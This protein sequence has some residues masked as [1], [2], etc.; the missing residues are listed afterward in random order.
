MGRGP[1][2]EYWG[3]VLAECFLLFTGAV[4]VVIDALVVD[5]C[6]LGGVF[7]FDSRSGLL[8]YAFHTSAFLTAIADHLV[9]DDA[10]VHFWWIERFVIH[11]L[12]LDD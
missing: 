4:R 3:F 7:H 6:N 8:T 2:R 1:L 5:T 12:G 10:L 9:L 11:L